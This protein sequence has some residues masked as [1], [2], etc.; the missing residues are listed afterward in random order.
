MVRGAGGLQRELTEVLDA[1]I[2]ERLASVPEDQRADAARRLREAFSLALERAPSRDDVVSDLNAR[3]LLA[4][5]V[6]AT[7]GPDGTESGRG[8]G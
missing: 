1:I 2:R 4:A 5:V 3:A 6:E 8:G 7:L